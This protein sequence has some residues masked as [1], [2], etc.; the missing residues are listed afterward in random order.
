MQQCLHALAPDAAPKPATENRKPE[1]ANCLVKREKGGKKA[2]KAS[3]VKDKYEENQSTTKISK[4]FATSPGSFLGT[5][6]SELETPNWVQDLDAG[7][8]DISILNAIGAGRP[9]PELLDV[10]QAEIAAAGR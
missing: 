9:L 10:F 8:F 6:N 5:L 4:N 1:T 2:G 7:R 3:S